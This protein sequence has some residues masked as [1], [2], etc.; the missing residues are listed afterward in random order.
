MTKYKQQA[1]KYSQL[2]AIYSPF[3]L[4]S[5]EQFRKSPNQSFRG[6]LD[7]WKDDS[8]FRVSDMCFKCEDSTLNTFIYKCTMIE[9]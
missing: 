5:N 9:C 3:L 2:N 7:I 1:K 4:N 8:A 6:L